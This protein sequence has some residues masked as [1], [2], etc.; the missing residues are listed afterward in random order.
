MKII[1]FLIYVYYSKHYLH[2]ITPIG[3]IVFEGAKGENDTEL[4]IL[5]KKLDSFEKS[6]N[7]TVYPPYLAYSSSS[8]EEV[9]TKLQVIETKNFE[10]GL[11]C[12]SSAD[13]DTQLMQLMHCDGDYS[14]CK[15]AL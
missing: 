10:Q 11:Y 7:N 3:R 1:L 4:I 9:C 15:K 2:H 5:E 8:N 13:L 12:I 14:N 6:T